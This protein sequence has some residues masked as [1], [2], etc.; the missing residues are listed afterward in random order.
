MCS[1]AIWRCQAGKDV[2]VEKPVSHNCWEGRKMVEA[3]RKYKR[4]VQ[5]GMQNRSA[6]YNMAAKKYIEGGKLG[7]FT[8]CRV[9]NQKEWPNFP[10]AAE[11]P[12][13]AEFDWDMWT[14]PAADKP[15][16]STYVNYWNHFWRYSGGDIIN[17][18][19]HQIDLARWCSGRDYP[20]TVYSVGGRYAEQ[21]R[22]ESPDTQM[23]VL[24]FD[25]LVL[26]FELTLYTPYMLKSD[27]GIRR[28]AT[29]YLYWP[30]MRERIEIYGS[31]G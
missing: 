15:Y 16:N 31:E 3:A 17:D 1:A 19:I 5:V 30:Q 4:V 24:E 23:A 21:G 9:Y 25:D 28:S 29:M 22:V 20:K 6:A 18:G 27:H 7:R 10:L 2:Y 11:T 13:P 12:L 14:G 8:S 26:N